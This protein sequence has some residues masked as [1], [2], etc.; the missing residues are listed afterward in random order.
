M[1]SVLDKKINGMRHVFSEEILYDIGARLKRS[2][3]SQWQNYSSK[4]TFQSPQQE[5]LQNY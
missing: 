3:K 4:P 2:S 1:G 5:A